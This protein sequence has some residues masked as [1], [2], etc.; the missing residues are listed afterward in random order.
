MAKKVSPPRPQAVERQ[1]TRAPERPERE[2]LLG[3]EDREIPTYG[4]GLR[5][6]W[7]RPETFQLGNN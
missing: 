5:A 6:A 3:G 2:P 4:D 7:R 1:E